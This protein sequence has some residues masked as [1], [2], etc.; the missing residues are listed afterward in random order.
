MENL[1]DYSVA[2]FA[3]GC[4]WCMEAAFQEQEGVVE[5]ISGYTGGEKENPSYNEVTSG[6]TGHYEAVQVYYD[7]NKISY[8]Q[9]VEIFWT[10]IDP[11]DTGGQFS[12]RGSQYKTAIFYH[13]EKQR[14]AAEKSKLELSQSGMF[15]KPIVTEIL[16]AKQF[17]NAEEYHQDYYLKQSS[18]YKLYKIGSVRESFIKKFWGD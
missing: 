6:S 10:Q 8:E 14:E 12:D 4:F 3:G 5:V 15:E 11:T 9:L 16:P 7:K 13:D 2:T 17:Y 1:K 18:N